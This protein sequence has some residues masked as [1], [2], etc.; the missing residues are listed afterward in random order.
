MGLAGLGD[1]IL[2][3]TDNQ[4]RNRRFGM[5]LGSGQSR[6]QAEKNIGQV[7]E[8]IETAKSIYALAML[9]KVE[10]PIAFQVYRILFENLDPRLAVINLLQRSPKAE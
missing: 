8:G 2:T 5:L 1:L 7:V 10:M 6:Q 9:Q 3:C 4:S